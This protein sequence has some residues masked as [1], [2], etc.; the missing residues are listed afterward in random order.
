MISAMGRNRVIGSGDGMPWNVPEEYAQFLSL[1]AGQTM[2]M[3]RKSW[4][5]FGG[6]LDD[7]RA[8]VVS[9]SLQ[10]VAGAEVA[11]SLN[12]ALEQ[13]R[14]GP[15]RLFVAGGAQIYRQALP[16]AEEMMLS[17]IDGDF[18]G[19]A[20]FPEFDEAD[21]AVLERRRHPEFQ[22]VHYRRMETTTNP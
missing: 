10:R 8:I 9:R 15:G 11:H 17:Y 2:I 19:D 1:V 13:G 12:E 4:E 6:D 22:F 5:I 20:K 3:G 7:V 16:S 18:S 21:W 14:R